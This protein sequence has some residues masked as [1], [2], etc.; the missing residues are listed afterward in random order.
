MGGD[1]G[2]SAARGR[3][4]GEGRAKWR[5]GRTEEPSIAGV[6]EASAPAAKSKSTT[7]TWWI[8]FEAAA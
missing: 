5:G 3:W 8:A 4:A 7:A 1:E 6:E 2:R